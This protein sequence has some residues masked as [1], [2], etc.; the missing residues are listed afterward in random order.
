MYGPDDWRNVSKVC[1]D[2]KKQS[3]INIDTSKV[4]EEDIYE[5]K[6][7]VYF[8][9]LYGNIVGKLENNGHAPTFKVEERR[10]K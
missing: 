6:R 3:P 10:W 5:G 7:L 8:D 9:R 1:K 4:K 2:G